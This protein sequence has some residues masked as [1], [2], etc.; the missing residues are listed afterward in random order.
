MS[1]FQIGSFPHDDYFI[2]TNG[3]A[4]MVIEDLEFYYDAGLYESYPRTGSIWYDLSGN[5]NHASMTGS[6]PFLEGKGGYFQFENQDGYF[7]VDSLPNITN[8]YTIV[9]WVNFIDGYSGT[10]FIFDFRDGATDG[11]FL[12]ANPK[13]QLRKNSTDTIYTK[14]L[15]TDEWIMAVG[16]ISSFTGVFVNTAFEIGSI[17]ATSFSVTTKPKIGTRSF[18]TPA[19]YMSGSIAMVAGFSKVLTTNEIEYIYKA[20]RNSFS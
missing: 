15:R 7:S 18:S 2:E 16:Y 11:L 12:G 3:K 8:T 4:S 5:G 13:I 6:V 10:R 14:E 9:A 17:D 19:N 20:T 1:G